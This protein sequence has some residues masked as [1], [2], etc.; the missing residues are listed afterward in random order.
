MFIGDR[1]TGVGLQSKGTGATVVNGKKKYIDNT[2]QACITNK[3][4]TS[5]TYVYCFY[6][7]HYAVQ[8]K[9]IKGK[10]VKFKNKGSFRCINIQ[11][12]MSRDTLPALA[13]GLSGL[14]QRTF[15][16]FATSINQ[17]N[18][19]FNNLTSSFVNKK[20]RQGSDEVVTE[21]PKTFLM[22]LR[23]LK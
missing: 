6:K 23:L 16:I 21:S 13:I 4:S 17:F 11:S 14:A 1:D 12:I 8:Q 9:I 18:T 3:N 2:T 7:P 20:E 19:D 5:Q 15:P 22:V 10:E